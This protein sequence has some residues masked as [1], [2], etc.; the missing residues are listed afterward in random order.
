LFKSFEQLDLVFST[1]ADTSVYNADLCYCP[2]ILTV[3]RKLEADFA[4]LGE[5]D[6]VVAQVE[7]DLIQRSPVS[8]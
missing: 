8:L 1:D 5:L 7:N 6:G 3:P 2:S 4:V